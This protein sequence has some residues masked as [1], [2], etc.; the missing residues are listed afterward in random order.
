[1]SRKRIDVDEVKKS[2][3]MTRTPNFL[4][5]QYKMFS[6]ILK[7]ISGNLDC[8]GCGNKRICGL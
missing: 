2:R 5:E 8:I 6:P 3:Y 4:C 1:M 7:P